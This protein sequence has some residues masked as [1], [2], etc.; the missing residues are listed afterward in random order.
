M[1]AEQADV[2]AKN[3]ENILYDLAVLAEWKFDNEIF[4]RSQRKKSS[5]STVV[6]VTSALQRITWTL[7]RGLRLRP[8]EAAQCSLPEPLMN[9]VSTTLPWH[10]AISSSG[11]LAAVLQ[12]NC[13]E[14]R[15][16]RDS[17]ESALGRGTIPIDP[18][19]QWRRLVWSPD[20]S[21]VAC[22]R[23][24]GMVDV[25][26]MVGTLL[27]SIQKPGS[28]STGILQDLSDSVSAL[29]FTDLQP[30]DKRWS[31]ELLVIHHGGSL[32]SYLVDRDN[33]FV[34][35]HHFLFT[36]T[37]PL[38]VTAAAYHA[39][40]KVLYVGGA[41]MADPGE[42][43]LSRGAGLTAW[44]VLSDT[45]H[46]KLLNDTDDDQS[47]GAK[48]KSW[49]GRLKSSAL[50]S[51]STPDMD[52]VFR[53]CLSPDGQSLVGLH[54]SGSLSVWDVPSLRLR[55]LTTLEEQPGY[56]E[57]N[58]TLAENP[59]KRKKMKDLIPHRNLVD[60]NFWSSQ[61]V[62]LARCSG[63]VTVS[64]VSSLKNL[65]G[66]SPEWFE[67]SPRVAEAHDGGFLGLECELHF[68]K[69]RILASSEEDVE[70][71][72]D[73]DLSMVAMT[74]RATKQ[75]MFYLTDS[76]RFQPPKK[77]PK[78][79]TKV[80]RMVWL[81][82]TS[83]EELYAR[84]IDAEEYGEA[85]ALAQAYSLDCDLVYQRQ[86]RR[87]PVSLA[88]I[89]DYLSKISKRTW[90]LHECLERVPE[91]MDAARELLL[92]GLRGTDLPALA[93]ITS[94]EDAGR[95][96]LCDPEEGLYEDADYDRFNPAE[97]QRYE[98]KK[99]ALRQEQLALVDFSNLT[100]DQKEMCRARLKLLQYLDRLKTYECILGGGSAAAERFSAEF[101]KE[102]R[103]RNIVQIAAEYAQ[104]SDWKALEILFTYH[105]TDLAPHRLAIVSNFP[106]TT[107][108]ADYSCLLPEMG[109]D[110]EIC[111]LET[112]MWREQDWCELDMCRSVVQQDQEDQGAFLYE[113]CPDLL[114]FR[115]DVL[116][117]GQVEEWYERRACEI[118]ECSRLVDY[119]LELTKLAIQRGFQGL[120]DLLDDLV[121]M[122]TLVYEC[123]VG[124]DLTF[125][126]L[127]DMS[128]YTRIELMMDKCPQDMY[129]KNAR[130]WLVPVLQRCE[131]RD[132]GAYRRL[133]QE[134]LLTRARTDLTV[135]LTIFQ[136]SKAGV[137]NPIVTS[138]AD[139]MQFALDVLYTTERDDQLS[140]A[141]EIFRCLPQK[142]QQGDS[143]EL[144]QL[145]K[146]VD[147]LERH[148]RAAQILQDNGVHKTL[149][150]LK[151]SENNSEEA[152]N[153]IVRL[154][155]AAGR[156]SPG[157]KES[158]WYKLHE[159]IMTLH[160][161]LYRCLAPTLCHQIFVESLLCSGSQDNIRLAGDM[162][163]RQRVQAPGGGA[164]GGR[165]LGGAGPGRGQARLRKLEYEVAVT[166]VLS[167][168]REYF[169]SSANL[170]HT[171]MD[172]ARL[173][174]NLILDTP[175]SVQEE[176]D[177][178]SSL[179]VLDDFCVSVLPLQVRLCKDR[180]DLVRQAVVSKPHNYK[181]SQK[182]LRL[183]HLLRVE[184][185]DSAERDGKVLLLLTQAAL[186][187][188]DTTFAH[189][190][191]QQLVTASY[192]PAWTVCV[193]LAEQES[194]KD[195]AAKVSLLSFAVTFCSADMIEP[196][197]QARSLL[198]R[199]LLLEKVGRVLSQQ[200]GQGGQ[201][202]GEAGR[203]QGDVDITDRNTRQ[204]SPFSARAALE[205]TQAI[206][207][208]TQRHT[209]AVL[210]SVTDTA[211]WKGAM[212]S[213]QMPRGEGDAGKTAGET[214]AGF[215]RQG[216]HP[217][218]EDVVED[219]YLDT[220]S[221]DYGDIADSVEGGSSLSQ[222]V[223]RM[224]RLE[225]M[226]T[227]GEKCD[228]A[229]EALLE[230]GQQWLPRDT[231]LGLAYLL[232]L[233]KGEAADR[234]LS[235]IPQSGLALEVA[236]WYYTLQLYSAL[237][238]CPRPAPAPLY[239][240]PPARLSHLVTHHLAAHPGE[241]WGG[242]VEEGVVSL[243]GRSRGGVEEWRQAQGLQRLAPGVDVDRFASDPDYKK[244]TILG[245][246]MSCEEEVYGMA[247]VLADR[248]KL[249]LW[250]VYMA[251]LEFLFS[252]SGLSTEEV[253]SRMGRL[254]MLDTLRERPQ[255]FCSRLY[256]HV[257]PSVSGSDH[258]R[259]L[260]LFSLLEGH[261]EQRPLCGL[262]AADHAKLLKK[263]R[264]VAS[265]IDYVR[266]MD[267]GTPPKDLLAPYLTASNINTI[268]K[269]ATRIPDKK[270]GFLHPSSLYC[271]WA[272][273]V[274][275]EG[276]KPGKAPPQNAAAWIHRYETC[277][278]FIQRLLPP[279]FVTFITAITCSRDSS[280]QL[281]VSCRQE[282]V[283]RAIKV[284]HSSTGKKKKDNDPQLEEEWKKAEQELLPLQRHLESLD[285][286][287]IKSFFLASDPKFQ[288]Y[289]LNYDLSCGNPHKVGQLLV[290]MVVEG[291][292]L[293]LVEDLVTVAPPLGLTVADVLRK[294]LQRN[295]S[296]LRG[297]EEGEGERKIYDPLDRL[298]NILE[299]VQEHIENLGEL[300]GRGDVFDVLHPYVS[301]TTIS[302]QHRMAVLELLEKTVGLGAQHASILLFCKTVRVVSPVWGE[303]EVGEEAV[304]EEGGR[305]ALF[306][307][308]LA[309]TS[310]ASGYRALCQL[311]RLWPDFAE[312][313]EGE[314]PW[315][316]TLVA[317]ASSTNPATVSLID[318]VLSDLG[319]AD[320]P[321]SLVDTK[322]VF[323]TLLRCQHPMEGVKVVL[324]SA[325]K[326]LYPS[327]VLVLSAEEE[328][329]DGDLVD[330][331]LRRELSP[332]LVSTPVYGAVCR[333]VVRA[334]H[335]QGSPPP[336]HLEL[337][338]VVGQLQEA[339]LQAEA[340]AL[341]QQAQ[342]SKP[343]L[344]SALGAV[345]SW[346]KS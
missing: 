286:D 147:R 225:E 229:E 324:R 204:G 292:P 251:H 242:G 255:E 196:I 112:D 141:A 70:D 318:S 84:K 99:K 146:Q 107:W 94:G 197:L 262:S 8:L 21:M 189:Q 59:V 16:I 234:C 38:G 61:A 236:Q 41:A 69:Q 294:A 15:S 55:R 10:L 116:T 132:P 207:S 122:E 133:L 272:I 114:R 163:E 187:A 333:A 309:G 17:F 320:F 136:T 155:R 291:Q 273:R 67:P 331:V 214:N 64:S 299:N 47:M 203:E 50:F 150:F 193:D 250:D 301:D 73:E 179:G 39:R 240:H 90:V 127:R 128:D 228:H 92:Y 227:E 246:A 166:L 174:L 226:L 278:E 178:I 247:V 269:L 170:T 288:Q 11:S 233:P 290:L 199:Q 3:D 308:L 7:L 311:L 104:C 129:A 142:T 241:E 169:D 78:T 25:F 121:T 139:L 82:S 12:E 266:L 168:A 102:F 9:L 256:T 103:T 271:G 212:Q 263:L 185:K 335:R 231:A 140:I 218:Y 344:R 274:F 342:A 66:S 130:R 180:L 326:K 74:T 338:T 2:D 135:P 283:R 275:W 143:P 252:D 110:G 314:S 221:I 306:S 239:L 268:M 307:Q 76:E 148:L 51:W 95:F 87:S 42:G 244:E 249:P 195:I 29:I 125:A 43:S 341:T 238:P 317:M 304:Q 190:C 6:R 337:D 134:F 145:H 319:T 57:V 81:K 113:H 79:V 327:A 285:S 18:F 177:L 270:G 27:F 152:N 85:L 54:H 330:L 181:Q 20:E 153:L 175:P 23:S 161:I 24:S 118:E 188:G 35:R 120:G 97:V 293:E 248:Y 77:K 215:S 109:S 184:G 210:S 267:E 259:L 108:P 303:V 224:A 14:I 346:F 53:L 115:V 154:T 60:I 32:H 149:A 162:M 295:V 37:F 165:G 164:S 345:G 300:A 260:Y 216:C 343:S 201:E 119:A 4:T 302:M 208:S 298:E 265:D 276:D 176:L 211:W 5:T 100:L 173:C 26:D 101:Y 322:I 182:M 258:P 316:Q 36:H 253:K 105:H 1:A 156:K 159:D 219:A 243:M 117:A 45:P 40:H 282:I 63:A 106:E 206:L 279:D 284:C 297:E 13:V 126:A 223:L 86:W 261:D 124:D 340:R 312:G 28:E 58:A 19:P 237:R 325:H 222:S 200:T 56:D 310:L 313:K 65:L 138:T 167:A 220:G 202:G 209:R 172:L 171:C 137:S 30:D 305:L 44:R 186:S 281:E 289:G 232:S 329:E 62:I 205:Q 183:A 217:F 91:S 80:Y 31:G 336:P 334:H 198:H 328:V 287:T 158:E 257:Y 230:L 34:A 46:Y 131:G 264:T 323:D 245:L 68:P 277:G 160:D 321:L 280:L 315:T 192:G 48:R 123:G 52:G 254:G 157:L 235:A 213:L 22:A 49:F 71:S 33:G 93:A 191:C 83:P 111:S 296:T 88:S 332:Q 72:D 98:E 89:Q 339:G 144:V 75:I 194:F 151:T 96:M